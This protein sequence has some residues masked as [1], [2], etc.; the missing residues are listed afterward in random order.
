MISNSHTG[1]VSRKR[2]SGV[3]NPFRG[4]PTLRVASFTIAKGREQPVYASAN[5]WVRRMGSI[6][7]RT[8]A[9]FKRRGS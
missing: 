8:E 9:A 2:A 5:E 4:T 1:C 7:P 6:P 3:L